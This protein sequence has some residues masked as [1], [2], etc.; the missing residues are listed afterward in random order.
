MGNETAASSTPM[1]ARRGTACAAGSTGAKCCCRAADRPGRP[2]AGCRLRHTWP[3]ESTT[4]VPWPPGPAG[5][6]RDRGRYG[7][8]RRQ[9]PAGGTVVDQGLTLDGRCRLDIAAAMRDG[10]TGRLDGNRAGPLCSLQVNRGH[11]GP[12]AGQA[13]QQGRCDGLQRELGPDAARSAVDADV[14]PRRRGPVMEVGPDVRH[15]GANLRQ[16]DDDNADPDGIFVKTAH[17]REHH[18]PGQRRP[19]EGADEHPEDQV[20]QPDQTPAPLP[21]SHR[22]RWP[23]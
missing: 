19:Q 8:R 10:P 9:I 22:G 4:P 2:V 11:D 6:A 7:D 23:P 1:A 18:G 20:A 21:R 12:K 14:A 17:Q 5:S 3:V 13:D 15:D 16:A